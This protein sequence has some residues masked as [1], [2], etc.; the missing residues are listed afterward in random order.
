MKR[1]HLTLVAELVREFKL[2]LIVV[3]LAYLF[4]IWWLA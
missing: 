4:S 3:A 2:P 1:R